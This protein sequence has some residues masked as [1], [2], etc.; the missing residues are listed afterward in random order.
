MYK[1]Y[2]L[3]ALSLAVDVLLLYVAVLLLQRKLLRMEAIFVLV[4]GI[5]SALLD[6]AYTVRMLDHD[7]LIDGGFVTKVTENFQ[8]QCNLVAVVSNCFFLIA[9]WMLI[10]RFWKGKGLGP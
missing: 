1:Y 3:C 7:Q 6:A 8:W 9:I 5:P 2:L 10:V 4:Y